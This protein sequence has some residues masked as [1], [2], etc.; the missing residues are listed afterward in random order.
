MLLH[1]AATTR[2][3]A[4][5][6]N[7]IL[8]GDSHLIV[9]FPTAIPMTLV[10][11]LRFDFGSHLDRD[12]QFFADGQNGLRAY[13]NFAFEGSRR[14]LLNIEQR[15]FLGR[16]LL[17]IFEPGAAIFF[18]G[19]RLHGMHGDAGAGL[20]FSIPRYESAIIRIDAAYALNDSPISKRG[21]VMSIATTQA[22]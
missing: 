21:L 13:P 14:V 9:K 5:N 17:Q 2:A 10:S 6:R 18:D 15:F 20:R 19:A 7:A 16:E 1:V 22:F 11:R 8:S 12:V 4:T 3:G